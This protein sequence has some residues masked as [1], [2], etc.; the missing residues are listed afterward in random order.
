MAYSVLHNTPVA[1]AIQWTGMSIQYLGET[2]AIAD[3][4]TNTLYAYWTIQYPNNLVVTNEFPV[5]GPDDCLIFVNKNGMAVIIPGS[6]VVTGDIIMP[7][8]ILAGALAANCI[9]ADKLAAG[10]VTA[11]AIAAGAVTTHSLAAGSVTAQAVAADAI[12]AGA[13]A[14]DAVTAD[15]IVAGAITTAHIASAAVTANEIAAGAIT[16]A[17]LK[18][19]SVDATKIKAGSITTNHLSP[20]FGDQLVIG[21]NPALT[22]ITDSVAAEANRAIAV[23]GE[24]KNFTDRA[25]AFFVFDIAAGMMTIGKTGSPFTS[26]FSSTKLSFKQSGAEVAYISNNK[27]YISVAQVMDILTIGNATE[28]YVDLDTKLSGLRASWRAE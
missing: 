17:K 28:G 21:A 6:S 5:L 15:V 26:E 12:G 22:E 2:Y 27:L 7:G 19:E 1:G 18:A 24:L 9:T 14:A 11:G 25:N 20:L 10:A 16:T 4:Y 8:T 23:E 3:G 13:I